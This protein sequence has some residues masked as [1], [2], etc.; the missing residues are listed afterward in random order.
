MGKN[1]TKIEIMEIKE[2]FSTKENQCKINR[3]V[4]NN[5]FFLF[6]N[7]LNRKEDS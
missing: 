7:K 2:G 6:S 1:Y 3:P 4:S 5:K